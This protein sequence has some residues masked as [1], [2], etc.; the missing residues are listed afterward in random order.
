MHIL[1]RFSSD[2]ITRTARVIG[3]VSS[4]TAGITVTL[5]KTVST[6]EDI[7]DYEPSK[8]VG[9]PGKCIH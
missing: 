3:I 8:R 5:P 1:L 9:G 4:G 7:I 6:E 2:L